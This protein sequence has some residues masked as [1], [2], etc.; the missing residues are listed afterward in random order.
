MKT[1]RSDSAQ[2]SLSE[3]NEENVNAKIVCAPQ[4]HVHNFINYLAVFFNTSHYSN[5]VDRYFTH[6]KYEFKNIRDE[7]QF[8]GSFV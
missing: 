6:S 5:N 4:V 3:S 1:T 2:C 7:E 8:Y